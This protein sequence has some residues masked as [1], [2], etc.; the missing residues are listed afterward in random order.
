MASG[1]APVPGRTMVPTA[2]LPGFSRQRRLPDCSGG[3]EMF[4]GKPK[5]RATRQGSRITRSI[6]SPAS[7]SLRLLNVTQNTKPHSGYVKTTLYWNDCWDY[8]LPFRRHFHS[9]PTH[10]SI[11]TQIGRYKNVTLQLSRA[12]YPFMAPWYICT[13]NSNILIHIIQTG[14]QHRGIGQTSRLP[15]SRLAPLSSCWGIKII[16]KKTW[17]GWGGGGDT[18][19]SRL[20]S[21]NVVIYWPEQSPYRS[22]EAQSCNTYWI[23][24]KGY[25][26]SIYWC[27]IYF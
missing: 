5:T 26:F 20:L 16:I 23:A 19:I 25:C 18:P 13:I 15:N 6:L 17:Q 8:S 14:L 22:H 12:P 1:W 10:A 7:A 24:Y 3:R 11:T 21:H 27:L 2:A 9:S 4:T